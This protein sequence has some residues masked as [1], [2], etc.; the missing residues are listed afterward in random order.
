[1]TRYVPNDKIVI[2]EL[3]SKYISVVLENV[4]LRAI[5]SEIEEKFSESCVST[6]E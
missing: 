2:D 6:N 3:M 1:M 5:I 4:Q